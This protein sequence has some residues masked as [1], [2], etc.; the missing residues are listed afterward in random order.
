[1]RVNQSY[2]TLT[3]D[4]VTIH[5]GYTRYDMSLHESLSRMQNNNGIYVIT[6]FSAAG[7][8]RLQSVLLSLA[9]LVGH[10]PVG[11]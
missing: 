6:V 5:H 10:L 1:M 7:L 9:I 4:S 2:E 3:N 8:V 11:P